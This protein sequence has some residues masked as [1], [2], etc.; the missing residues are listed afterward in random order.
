[1]VFRLFILF[2]LS[3]ALILGSSAEAATRLKVLKLN[4]TATLNGK[5]LSE[6]MIVEESGTIQTGKGSWLKLLTLEWEQTLVLG[7]NSEL[8]ADI[9]TIQEKGNYHLVRGAFRWL[10]AQGKADVAPNRYHVTSPLA[11]FG[12][13]G[14]D[15][16]ILHS[17]TFGETE[18]IVFEGAVKIQD[19]AKPAET[20]LIR[21]GYW[22]GKGGR[23][24]S[25]TRAPLKLN[26][27]MLKVFSR[28]A[29]L[30]Q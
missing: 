17:P 8:K 7:A 10:S 14:T 24:G 26:A 12:A 20:K 21:A 15:F 1:M 2:L 9:G 30:E 27:E 18:L 6:N 3:S 5:A 4:G 19:S 23:F 13:R 25:S 29:P 11:S 22:S 16:L 28:E